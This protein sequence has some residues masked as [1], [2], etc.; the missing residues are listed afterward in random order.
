LFSGAISA[1]A[2]I[3]LSA[4]GLSAAQQLAFDCDSLSDGEQAVPIVLVTGPTPGAT[5]VP[6]ELTVQ[7]AAFDC[8][9]DVGSGINRVAVFLGRREGGGLHLGDAA[10]RRSS[11]LR[12]EPADQYAAVGWTLTAQAP[13]TPGKINELFVYARS[14]LTHLET[15]ITV[16]VLGA[17]SADG[18]VSAPVATPIPTSAT[19]TAVVLP[20]AAGPGDGDGEMSPPP[21][22]DPDEEGPH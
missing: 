4:P 8:H 10:L 3:A 18:A 13:L 14:E 20:Q 5:L 15:V 22:P 19:P 11:P 12:V 17:G 6:G 7:G 16:S 21:V 2:V 9:A 1:I